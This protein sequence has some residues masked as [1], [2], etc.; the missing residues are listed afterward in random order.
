MGRIIVDFVAIS[1]AVGLALAL[2]EL[3]IG[4]ALAPSGSITTFIA[5][6]IC[7]Q[8][9]GARDGADVSGAFAW[10]VAAALLAVVLALSAIVLALTPDFTAR[11]SE[12]FSDPELSGV[13]IAAALILPLIVFLALR[14]AFGLGVSN[15]MKLR[16]SRE[17]AERKKMP[18]DFE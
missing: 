17:E 5:A 11:F 2:L 18:R 16:Q 12:V 4:Q 15:G 3:A 10:K 9:Y 8:L 6:L 7:G 14:A 13:L 1:I